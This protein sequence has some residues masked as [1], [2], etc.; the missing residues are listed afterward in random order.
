VIS[1]NATVI[2]EGRP[3]ALELANDH[4]W[5]LHVLSLVSEGVDI[6][7]ITVHCPSKHVDTIK[8]TLADQFAD[9]IV[10]DTTP[11]TNNT[12]ALDE[13]YPRRQLLSAIRNSTLKSLSNPLIQISSHADIQI[14]A[15]FFHKD[16]KG[17]RTPLLRYIYRPTSR[18]IARVCIR[19]GITPNPITTI[20]LFVGLGG[21]SSIATGEY[22]WGVVGAVLVNAFFLLDLVDGDVARLSVNRSAFGAWFDSIV[23]SVIDV[24]TIIGFGIGSAMLGGPL[25]AIPAVIWLLSHS[26]LHTN[27]LLERDGRLSPPAPANSSRSSSKFFGY[28]RTVQWAISQPEIMRVIFAIGLIV[29]IPHL[30][31]AFYATFSTYLVFRMFA[32]AY[33]QYR[34]QLI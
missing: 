9:A 16:S 18:R 33:V 5:I 15:D 11:P 29:G 23:D 13:V 10:T 30:T 26:I 7:E 1:I 21:A 25:W 31:S 22:M 17:H 20:A 4:P 6:S 8:T 12:I 27:E 34:R 28:L 24:S 19:L 3:L 2:I 32:N 14:A